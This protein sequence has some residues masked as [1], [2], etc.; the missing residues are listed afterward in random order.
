MADI[1]LVK[2]MDM[3]DTLAEHHRSHLGT[4]LRQRFSGLSNS[5]M[6]KLAPISMQISYR[7]P[8]RHQR[9]V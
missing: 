6:S 8:A 7:G 1:P 2:E 9:Q 4:V 5:Q 3:G